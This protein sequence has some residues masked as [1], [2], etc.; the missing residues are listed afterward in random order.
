MSK[1]ERLALYGVLVVV[2]LLVVRSQ[3]GVAEARGG[4]AQGWVRADAAPRIATCD[5]YAVMQSLVESDKYK[6]ARVAGQEKA[7]A[8]LKE[9]AGQ[10][11]ALEQQLKSMD[12]KDE[13]TLEIF[14]EFNAKKEMFA[15]RQAELDEFLGNQFVEA[16]E[17]VRK[18]ADA[19]GEREGYSHVLVT[20]RRDEKVSNNMEQVTQQMLSRPVLR[21]PAADDITEKVLAELGL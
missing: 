18:A 13:K 8:E 19:V 21:A 11:G 16:Y 7:R 5:V 2:G 1:F 17:Q 12:P 15:E 6:P 20:R 4:D 9:I 3:V 10:I 14:R